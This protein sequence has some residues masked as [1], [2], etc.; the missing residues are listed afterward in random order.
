MDGIDRDR[1]RDSNGCVLVITAP[2]VNNKQA[3][4]TA[5]CVAGER[6]ALDCMGT[7]KFALSSLFINSITSCMSPEILA[8]LMSRTRGR[9]R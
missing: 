9:S 1:D 7:G 6:V 8:K 4:D 2:L 5:T 3:Q